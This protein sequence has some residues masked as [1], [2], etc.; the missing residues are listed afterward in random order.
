MGGKE[1][2]TLNSY[3]LSS[4]G[5][6]TVLR[7]DAT[8]L[9]GNSYFSYMNA[10]Y[11][12]WRLLPFNY[13]FFHDYDTHKI[14]L[15]SELSFQFRFL[16]FV[17]GRAGNKCF[18]HIIELNARNTIPSVWAWV[19]N[20]KLNKKHWKSCLLSFTKESVDETLTRH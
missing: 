18:T 6:I 9:M 8:F 10:A 1:W 2:A 3:I 7:T 14:N 11:F 15:V 20:K 5:K 16:P 13:N 12:T 19:C 17:L 4:V